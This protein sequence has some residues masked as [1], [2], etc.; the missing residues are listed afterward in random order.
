MRL[1]TFVKEKGKYFQQKLWYFKS[2]ATEYALTLWLK[3]VK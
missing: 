3:S 1:H 2:P